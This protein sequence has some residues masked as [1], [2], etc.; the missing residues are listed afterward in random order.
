MAFLIAGN[1][2]LASLT[3]SYTQKSTS[4]LMCFFYPKIQ[5]VN[6]LKSSNFAPLKMASYEAYK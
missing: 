1:D 2:D 4:K 6:P 5:L 3:C